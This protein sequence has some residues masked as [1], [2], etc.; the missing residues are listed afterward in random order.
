MKGAREPTSYDAEGLTPEE[1]EEVVTEVKRQ[2][3]TWVLG[4]TFK[5]RFKGGSEWELQLSEYEISKLDIPDLH[6]T[7]KTQS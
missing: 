7:G 5:G 6:V 2:I 3:E 4:H 1:A